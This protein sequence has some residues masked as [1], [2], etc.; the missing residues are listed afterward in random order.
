MYLGE[1]F[2]W[3]ICIHFLILPV[4]SHRDSYSTHHLGYIF[5]SQTKLELFCTLLTVDL[6]EIHVHE[7]LPHYS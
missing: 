7:Q 4:P 3:H 1:N 2:L 6:I 5:A